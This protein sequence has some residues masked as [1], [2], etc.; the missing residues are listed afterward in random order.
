MRARASLLA[1]LAPLVCSGSAMPDA[2]TSAQDLVHE[3]LEKVA[4][5]QDLP[6]V[7]VAVVP[8]EG[9]TRTWTLGED[10]DGEA[11]TRETPFLLGSVS[12]SFTAATIHDLVDRDVFAL[13]DR[14]GDLLPAHG[15][16]DPRA[17]DIT[18]D[19]LLT[20]TSG[21]TRADGLTHADRFDNQPGAVTRQATALDDVAL[22][23]DPGATFEYSDLNYLLLGAVVEAAS[24]DTFAHAVA[25]VARA[26]GIDL[27]TTREAAAALPPGHRQLF[28]QAVGFD[29]EYDASGAPYGYLGTDLDGISAWARAQLGGGSLDDGD[30]AA[31][32]A[33]RV[34]TGAGDRYGQGWRVGE[35]DGEPVIQ[36][37]GATPGYFAHVLLLPERDAAVVVLANSYSEARAAS[38]YSVAGDVVRIEQGR[39]AVGSVDDPRLLVAPFV[40]VGLAAAGLLVAVASRGRQGRRRRVATLAVSVPVAVLGALAPGLLGYS[41]E[42]LRL[43]SPDLGWGLWGVVLAWSVAAAVAVVGGRRAT[44]SSPTPSTATAPGR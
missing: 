37:T 25:R 19:D 7:A 3:H 16:P 23:A 34:E 27:I 1:L 6:G 38:L 15:I 10:G 41:S 13:D 8:L 40:V 35:L 18:V 12:K 14:L 33:G 32:H 42:Q 26:D 11:V 21:L 36:H 2:G 43:W 28:G 29:S 5:T 44:P 17:D 20:H 9:R 22:A 39:P 30:L 4:D 24:D 31:M